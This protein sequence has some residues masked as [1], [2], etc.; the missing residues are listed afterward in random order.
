MSERDRDLEFAQARASRRLAHLHPKDFARLT[1][2]ELAKD[3]E[4]HG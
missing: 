3:L 4:K 2:E 1:I